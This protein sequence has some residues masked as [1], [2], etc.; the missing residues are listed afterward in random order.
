MRQI[1]AG[2]EHIH[3]HKVVHR[4]LKVC[5]VPASDIARRVLVSYKCT[6]VLA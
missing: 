4:D 6:N 5:G 2:V 1:F 3:A